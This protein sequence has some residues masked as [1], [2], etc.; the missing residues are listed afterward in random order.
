MWCMP[1]RMK[2]PKPWRSEAAAIA[3]RSEPGSST[4]S[5]DGAGP[6]DVDQE[7]KGQCSPGDEWQLP[8]QLALRAVRRPQAARVR[9]KGD[10]FARN[11]SPNAFGK[12]A[13]NPTDGEGPTRQGGGEQGPG[14][15]RWGSLGGA[16]ELAPERHA[17]VERSLDRR[18]LDAQVEGPD[19][20]RM[21]GCN[22]GDQQQL[23]P[24]GAAG[25]KG[26]VTVHQARSRSGVPARARIRAFARPRAPLALE[27]ISNTCVT[28]R[29]RPKRGGH[30]RSEQRTPTRSR[31]SSAARRLPDAARG[32]AFAVAGIYEMRSSSATE[33]IHRWSEWFIASS[34]GRTCRAWTTPP[35]PTIS[36]TASGRRSRRRPGRAGSSIRRC[37]STSTGS[38]LRA[39]KATRSCTTSASSALLWR[40]VGPA[41]R[42]QA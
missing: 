41:P 1:I 37:C 25:L 9:L 5:L 32:S 27:L 20:Q 18:P 11:R 16:R 2:S 34:W 40:W 31:Q 8:D 15:R 14:V 42:F 30:P 29:T 26:P 21:R 13:R 39:R 33:R 10:P 17:H 6:V 19:I 36:A 38:I 3:S 28:R 22:A 35:G 4:I 12:R 23:A 24:M 7:L